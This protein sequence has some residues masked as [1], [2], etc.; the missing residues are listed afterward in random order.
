MLQEFGLSGSPIRNA[1]SVAT[2]PQEEAIE[3]LEFLSCLARK[4][5][6]ASAR[7]DSLRRCKATEDPHRFDQ[8]VQHAGLGVTK[9]A[10]RQDSLYARDIQKTGEPGV[11]NAQLPSSQACAPCN[12]HTGEQSKEV[13]TS[14]GAV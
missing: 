13:F 11:T 5:L 8:D 10:V 3:I 2:R 7:S 12:F 4:R 1:P 9:R 6:I 14:P